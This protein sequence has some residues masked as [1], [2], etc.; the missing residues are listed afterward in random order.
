MLRERTSAR[1]C[2]RS[3]SPIANAL[4]GLPILT[5]SPHTLADRYLFVTLLMGHY[6]SY[7]D[8]LPFNTATFAPVPV[9][10]LRSVMFL[11]TELMVPRIPKGPDMTTPEDVRTMAI[12]L[13]SDGS[14]VYRRYKSPNQ[15]R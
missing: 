12:P 3:A 13:E 8:T 4:F 1:R 6:T 10:H 14:S 5:T 15:G 11:Y 7:N 2:R 9:S